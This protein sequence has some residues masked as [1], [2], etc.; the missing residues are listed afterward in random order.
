[1]LFRPALFGLALALA[2]APA[3]AA[4]Q[5]WIG[6]INGVNLQVARRPQGRK[7]AFVVYADY[8]A[9]PTRQRLQLKCGEVDAA[10]RDVLFCADDLDKYADLEEIKVKVASSI[11]LVF[12]Y[13]GRDYWCQG[14]IR[15]PLFCRVRI[16]GRPGFSPEYRLTNQ[17][18]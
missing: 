16:S 3:A 10:T 8:G 9:S 13:E 7:N 5:S 11:N 6:Q 14:S 17:N 4:A 2:L 18:R 15:G 12:S 1:M